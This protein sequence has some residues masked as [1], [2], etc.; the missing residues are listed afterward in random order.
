MQHIRQHFLTRLVC[1]FVAAVII[2]LSVD[3]PDF[4]DNSVPE[5]LSYND[6]ESVV[7]LILE[8]VMHID[9]A[10][11]EHDDNDDGNPLKV[12]KIID[13]V[14]ENNSLFYFSSPGLFYC[15]SRYVTYEDFHP[16]SAI[17]ELFQP[18]EV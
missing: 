10:V 8:D 4:Y 13:I 11:P 14:F 3:A 15:K 12:N 7:E 6:I 9:N 2:N 18:P 5:D 17:D 16:Q 1:G